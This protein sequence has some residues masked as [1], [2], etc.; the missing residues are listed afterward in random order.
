MKTIKVVWFSKTNPEEQNVPFKAE[1]AGTKTCPFLFWANPDGGILAIGD[2]E[3]HRFLAIMVARYRPELYVGDLDGA[4]YY[5][6]GIATEWSSQYFKVETPE[7]FR[8]GIVKAFQ[9]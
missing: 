8:D 1:S 6:E 3:S 5:L 7:E 9:P 4:G 2:A